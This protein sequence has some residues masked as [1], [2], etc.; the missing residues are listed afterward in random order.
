VP[1]GVED[2]GIEVDPEDSD[3]LRAEIRS[4]DLSD[5]PHKEEHLVEEDE[6]YNDDEPEHHIDG[7]PVG[8]EAYDVVDE[9]NPDDIALF[10]VAERSHKGIEGERTTEQLTIQEMELRQQPGNAVRA[11]RDARDLADTTIVQDEDGNQEEIMPAAPSP[12]QVYDRPSGEAREGSLAMEGDIPPVVIEASSSE[13]KGHDESD[14]AQPPNDTESVQ[15]TRLQMAA[16]HHGASVD[17]RTPPTATSVMGDDDIFSVPSPAEPSHPTESRTS[18]IALLDDGELP[19]PPQHG[20]SPSPLAPES[21]LQHDAALAMEP[22][23][24]SHRHDHHHNVVL[25]ESHRIHE[26][27]R[28]SFVSAIASVHG[29]VP[30]PDDSGQT[31]DEIGHA[32]GDNNRETEQQH[33]EVAQSSSSSQA[34]STRLEHSI[35]D[36][37]TENE[38]D[39]ED[40][41]RLN[42]PFDDPATITP[43]RVERT[44]VYVEV[45]AMERAKSISPED[46]RSI[47]QQRP[48]GALS[49][50]VTPM[51]PPMLGADPTRHHH[52]PVPSISFSSVR[53]EYSDISGSPAAHTRSQ[54]H[55]HK[56]RFGRGVFSHVV[57]VPHCSIGTEASREQ[58]GASDLGRVTKEEMGKKRDLN[59]GSTFT[60]RM[61]SDVE[62]LPENLE[63]QVRQL[64]GSDLLREGHIWLLP[65]E[66]VTPESALGRRDGDLNDNHFENAYH[67]RSSPR[68]QPSSQTPDRKRKRGSSHARSASSTRSDGDIAGSS[69]RRSHSPPRVR[70]PY[71]M[72][73]IAENEKENRQGGSTEKADGGKATDNKEDIH[74]HQEPSDVEV[75]IVET[76]SGTGHGE[77][78][79]VQDM[80][81]E[82][83][84]SPKQVQRKHNEIED[85]DVEELPNKKRVIEL[86]NGEGPSAVKVAPAPKKSGWLSWLLG[87]K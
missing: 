3:A 39:D 76:R 32:E 45:P 61:T 37:P 26:A 21:L 64:A 2:D 41:L 52:G 31:E 72:S 82:Q 77:G 59:F 79:D 81:S 62:P 1:L 50:P 5:I 44:E 53:S 27:K 33:G 78:N 70:V 57:L 56:I 11:K 6:E 74:L 18:V 73:Q 4:H 36:A 22:T 10:E 8:Y 13:Q 16:D 60:S 69:S 80:T 30:T 75:N 71:E 20:R 85:D 68:L 25:E 48:D 83:A 47:V 46:R 34:P 29:D 12:E 43:S 55:Y 14:V 63:H 84:I 40:P 17:S 7:L 35:Q 19:K 38:D 9:T 24:L 42:G 15:G 58:I 51:R 23:P 66:D 54:C 87:R 65:L 86:E 67:I 28:Q 49:V